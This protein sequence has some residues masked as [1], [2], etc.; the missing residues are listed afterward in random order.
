MVAVRFPAALCRTSSLCGCELY[1]A[2]SVAAHCIVKH[3][4]LTRAGVA[5]SAELQRPCSPCCRCLQT[6]APAMLWRP[7]AV[8]LWPWASGFHASTSALSRGPLPVHSRLST[9][10][11]WVVCAQHPS[12]RFFL[13]FANC[14]TYSSPEEFSRQ[15]RHAEVSQQHSGRP[16]L[17]GAAGHHQRLAVMQHIKRLP[18]V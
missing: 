10:C 3:A 15:L 4:R 9:D 13:T 5:E 1:D 16:V 7:P 18:P 8:R 12:N 14:L 11:R 17:L 6:P 2:M